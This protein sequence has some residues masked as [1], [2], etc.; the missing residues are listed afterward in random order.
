LIQVTTCLQ[1]YQK[2]TDTTLLNIKTWINSNLNNKRMMGFDDNYIDYYLKIVNPKT[3][4]EK[5]KQGILLGTI[6]DDDN[7][8]NDG[9]L[10]S[11]CIVSK[12]IITVI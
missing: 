3:E 7:L 4:D 10:F 5:Y 2:K 6:E 9:K 8:F 12:E 1:L 11:L